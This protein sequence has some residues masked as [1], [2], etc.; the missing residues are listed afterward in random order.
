MDSLKATPEEKLTSWDMY[1][2]EDI[3]SYVQR[4]VQIRH[5]EICTKMCTNK[6]T[7]WNMYE[8]EDTASIMAFIIVQLICF[9]CHSRCCI[10]LINVGLSRLISV[11]VEIVGFW[12]WLLLDFDCGYFWVH[13]PVV[14]VFV[15]WVGH[16]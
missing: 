12:L 1:E 11:F 6:K 8:E 15:N 7:S 9:F 13:L 10:L 14:F 5:H 3:M 2:E 4:C 16:T